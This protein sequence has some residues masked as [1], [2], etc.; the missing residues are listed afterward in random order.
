[1]ATLLDPALSPE[2]LPW[3]SDVTTVGARPTNVYGTFED[4]DKV[5]K[6]VERLRKEGFRNNDISVIF[7]DRDLSKEFA[8]E[9]NTKAP[10]GALAGGGT[11]LVLGS[12][13]GWLVGIG[14]IAIPGVGPLIAAGPIVAALAGAGV[15]SAVASRVPLSASV[16]LSLRQNATK[17]KSSAAASWYRFTATVWEQPVPHAQY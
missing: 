11:G 8:I 6:A 9:K 10:E 13:L 3:P 7:P 15:G 1:M 2:P 14:M 5:E 17:K 4:R 12:A 16:C